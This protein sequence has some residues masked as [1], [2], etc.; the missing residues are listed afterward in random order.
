MCTLLQ[1]CEKWRITLEVN[2]KAKRSCRIE[3]EMCD[4][5]NPCYC[6]PPNKR[7]RESD[8]VKDVVSQGTGSKRSKTVKDK[9][10]NEKIKPNWPPEFHQVG[11]ELHVYQTFWTWTGKAQ[12]FKVPKSVPCSYE[13]KMT[14]RCRYSRHWIQFLPFARPGNIWLRPSQSLDLLLRGS[15]RSEDVVL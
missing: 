8:T 9:K 13:Q 7:Q 2:R 15:W 5:T 11:F 4:V 14:R 12:L 1:S 3:I 10:K 6:M